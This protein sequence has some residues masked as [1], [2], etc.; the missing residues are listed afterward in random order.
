MNEKIKEKWLDALRS[1]AY[2]QGKHF[3]RT[4]DCFCCLGVLCDLYSK[5]TGHNWESP[6]LEGKPN[7]F[8]GDSQVLPFDVREWAG[9]P[10]C[11]PEIKI[12]KTIHS[13]AEANDAG[14]PF[15]LIADIIE[16]QL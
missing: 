7:K 6:I 13:L 11:N 4:D 14:V 8:L 5:E 15:S 12:T 3:L 2:V 9:L 10:S 1:D 16:E